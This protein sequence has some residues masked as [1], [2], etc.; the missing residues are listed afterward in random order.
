M[1]PSVRYNRAMQWKRALLRLW[2]ALSI[3]W[4]GGAAWLTYEAAPF[5]PRTEAGE[6][7][8][9]E[10]R[11][12]H[13]GRGNPFGCFEGLIMVDEASIAAN[14]LYTAYLPATIVPPIA[15]L[16]LGLSGLWAHRAIRRRSGVGSSNS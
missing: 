16:L 14:P 2:V 7:Q 6:R 5:Y 13:P 10:D 12:D 15:L 4:V 9:F 8:C 11:V 3:A 1:A